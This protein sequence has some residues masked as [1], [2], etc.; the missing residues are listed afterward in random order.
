LGKIRIGYVSGEFRTQATSILMT[1]LFE[2]HDKNQFEIFAIDNGTDDG[3]ELR[4]RMECAFDEFVD[5]S[6]LGD[7]EAVSEINKRNIDILVNLNGYFGG[8][9]PGLFS[10]R[11][12][13]IQVN[14]LGFP[15][16]IGAEYIDYLIADRIVIPENS[17]LHYLEKIVYLPNCYQ[18][19]DSQRKISDRVFTRGELGLPSAGF[20]FCCFNNNYKLTSSTFDCWMKILKRCE[21]AVL[22]LLEDN[23]AA[24]DNLRREAELRGVNPQRLVFAQ[25]LP[26]D[27][28]LARHR[29]ADLF[30]DTLPCNAHTTASDALWTGLPVLTQRGNTFPGRV[31]A[32]LLTAIGLSELITSSEAEYEELAVELATNP[33]RLAQVTALL[34][35][36]RQTTPLFDTQL[37]TKHIEAAYV[38]MYE[39][40]RLGLA[41]DH[42]EVE[43]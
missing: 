21:G 2:L 26:L 20:V 38:A 16:T 9:R 5:I 42:I 15:G 12:S 4:A 33:Q 25:R 1:Q 17:R 41:P 19:N 22:W 18:S 6:K 11:P 23:S 31:A 28:H 34:E 27:E 32:S 30:I 35:K 43:Q 13:P 8:A 37:F 3:G 39:R 29:L 10:H 36:N 14:Y 40:Y 7:L 24:A